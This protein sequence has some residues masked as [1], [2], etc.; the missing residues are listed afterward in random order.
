MDFIPRVTFFHLQMAGQKSS[1]VLA[2]SLGSLFL[3]TSSGISSYLEIKIHQLILKRGYDSFKRFLNCQTYPKHVD[4]LNSDYAPDLMTF[5]KLKIA[6]KKTGS[7]YGFLKGIGEDTI[8]IFSE[9]QENLVNYM[10]GLLQLVRKDE[11][12][13]ARCLLNDIHEKDSIMTAVLKEGGTSDSF[14]HAVHYLKEDGVLH[15]EN[16][17]LYFSTDISFELKE[18]L[19]DLIEYGLVKYESTY[20]ETEDDFVL[21]QGYR[22]DQVQRK[23]L[24]NPGYNGKGTYIYGDKVYIFASI[25]KDI[26]AEEKQHLNYKD[27]FIEADVFQWECEDYRASRWSDSK[28]LEEHKKLTNSKEAFL[29]IRKV[30]NE[31]GI[32]MPFIYVGTG[33]MTNPVNTEKNDPCSTLIYKIKMNNPLPDDLQY[34]F[35]LSKNLFS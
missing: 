11:Y 33:K 13:I 34:D 23:V 27:K 25:K 6:N 12:I 30:D 20:A 3:K 18:F 29:F 19:L 10:S 17:F 16:D 2:T 9:S 5:M 21:W 8:P 4:Y 28:I 1:L 26:T 22:Y 31:H 15:I 35:E 14:N 24:K 32:Q 7:Y